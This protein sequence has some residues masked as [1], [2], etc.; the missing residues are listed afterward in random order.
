MKNLLKLTCGLA[1]AGVF[2][3]SNLTTANENNETVALEEIS[4]ANEEISEEMVAKWWVLV[5]SDYVLGG[6]GASGAN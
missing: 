5:S 3:I 6:G 4:I 2:F 1:V